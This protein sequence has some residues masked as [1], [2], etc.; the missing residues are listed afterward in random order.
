MDEIWIEI[1]RP[2]NNYKPLTI[3]AISNRGNMKRRNGIIEPIPLRQC[4][5]I[6]GKYYIC[7]RLLADK[8]IPKT[9][10]D[11]S[12]GRDCVDHITHNPI[13]M[14]V[15]D[16]RNLRWCTIKENANFEEAKLHISLAG[17][18]K[19][20]SESCRRN[21]S[22]A[23]KG[24]PKSEETKRKISESKKGHKLTEE[25][26]RKISLKSKGHIV[27][28]EQKQRIALTR[29]GTK[30]KLGDDG[31]YHWVKDKEEDLKELP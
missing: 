9:E 15:N 11:I 4:I 27:T 31:K 1:E 20:R 21:I 5:K 7:S 19:K 6:L 17:L 14:N 28:E 23:L 18:G 12:L 8:F 13:D 3:I 25:H 26:K 10:E 2:I 24:K 22:N 29:K 30:L 16:I